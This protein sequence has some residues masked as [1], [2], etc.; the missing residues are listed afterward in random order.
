MILTQIIENREKKY[1][2]QT[3]VLYG[4]KPKA[5]TCKLNWKYFLITTTELNRIDAKIVIIVNI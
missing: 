5:N 2:R 3:I 1:Y 4:K